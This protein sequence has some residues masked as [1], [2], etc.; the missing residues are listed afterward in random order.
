MS[1]SCM[2]FVVHVLT[3]LARDCYHLHR[4]LQRMSGWYHADPQ[5]ALNN[6]FYHVVGNDCVALFD[7]CGYT[8]N[9]PRAWQH[10]IPANMMCA[11]NVFGS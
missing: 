11:A 10:D 5:G 6:V 7:S 1:D 2:F 3:Q 4:S 8:M 9:G